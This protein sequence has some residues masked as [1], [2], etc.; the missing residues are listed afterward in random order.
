VDQVKYEYG[1]NITRCLRLSW[2]SL[3]TYWIIT[4]ATYW[5]STRCHSRHTSLVHATTIEIDA[6]SSFSH[7]TR[8][9]FRDAVQLP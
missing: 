3:S 8:K 2:L 9:I 1:G 4:I 5:S 7:R 6:K